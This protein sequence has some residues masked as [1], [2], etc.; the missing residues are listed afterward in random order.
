MRRSHSRNRGQERELDILARV[1]FPPHGSDAHL[2]SLL[3]HVPIWDAGSVKHGLGPRGRQ[4]RQSRSFLPYRSSRWVTR[5]AATQLHDLCRAWTAAW[6][7][8]E[9][10]A[11]PV[12][13]AGSG[14]R[15]MRRTRRRRTGENSSQR[16]RLTWAPGKSWSLVRVW[17]QRLRAPPGGR[18]LKSR[19]SPGFRPSLENSPDMSG[20]DWDVSARALSV[21]AVTVAE[22]VVVEMEAAV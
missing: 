18:N 1:P 4:K 9:G 14:D 11:R 6:Q 8:R 3:H 20:W 19:Y 17:D 13:A 12:T 21:T 2:G 22:V 15:K 5:P 7:S 10:R 16:G